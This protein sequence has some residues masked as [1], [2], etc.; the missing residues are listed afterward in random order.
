MP[1]F[2][3]SVRSA[4]VSNAK[5]L[6]AAVCA[7][8]AAACMAEMEPASPESQGVDSQAILNWIDACERTF[9]GV[10]EGRVHGFVIVRH[11][12]TVAEGS[13]RPFDTL[14]E[15]HML[16]SHS[17]S[18][19]SSAVGF[20][21][22][23]GRLDLDERVVDIFPDELPEAPSDNLRQLR[24]RDLLTMNVGK[25]DHLLRAGG[26]WVREFLS[27]DFNRKPGTAFRYDSDATYM[28]A[29][30]VE[31]RT[32]RRL[33][34]F[35]KERMFDKIGIVSAWSTTSPQ[36]IACGGWGMNMTTREIARFG[37]L[38]LQDGKWGGEYVLSP[39]WTALATARHTASGW[40]N[41]GV[42]AL[43]QGGDWEQGYGF[44][45]WRC[46][47]GAYRADGAAGQYTVV[48]PD[49]DLV[50]S[51][52][53]GLTDMGKELALVW[54]HLLPGVK[55]EP[56]AEGEA[57][58]RLRKRLGALAIPP[59]SGGAAGLDKFLGKTYEFKENRRGIASF[60]FEKD[61]DSLFC[62][63]KVPAG[64]QRIPVGVGEWKKG[65]MRFDVQEY[66]SLGAYVGV[67]RTAASAGVDGSGALS[68]RIYL[69]GDT[70]YIDVAVAADGR[71]SGSFF[72]MN[73]TKLEGK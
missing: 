57:F 19:T 64:E 12:K 20:L 23:D 1:A 34:D 38:Y 55:P 61:G 6:S 73:G 16:Y 21:V 30:I 60:R 58:A 35:L 44:Q 5:T 11:G 43:G 63:L 9:D 22:D 62:V 45:F 28:L 14:N 2:A 42:K 36:G 4:V 26:D 37:Q 65:E 72:A 70:G 39:F 68:A 56:L 10:K 71:A 25:K 13:W 59:T 17:K 3:G 29:A 32:G 49:K 50:V 24:V 33:M 51:I 31:K 66:E 53:A 18:F 47:H 40:G 15:P 67:H 8:A 27:K 69:T 7:L 41:V 48:M 54:E 46:R 52:H